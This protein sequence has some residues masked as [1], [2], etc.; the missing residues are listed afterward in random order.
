MNTSISRRKFLA[1]A[2]A[3][4]ALVSVPAFARRGGTGF[5]SAITPLSDSETKLLVY[6]REEEKLARDVY[7]ALNGMWRHVTFERIAVAEQRHMDTLR[8][9]LDKYQIADPVQSAVGAF[10]DQSLQN[11]YGSLVAT[12]SKSLVNAL[13]VGCTIEDVDIMDLQVAMEGSTHV[14]LDVVY[15]H[16]MDGSRNHLRA[17]SAALGLEGASYTPQY[18][19]QE[20]YDAITGL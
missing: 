12:G 13:Q 16:L 4:S 7:L 5:L 2:I 9:I 18:M 19:S 8:K 11:L 6:M 20:M 3:V 14:E 15:Q 1:G 10:T 17:F